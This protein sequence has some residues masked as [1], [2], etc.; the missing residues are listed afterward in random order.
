MLLRM[1][2]RMAAALCA[3]EREPSIH[4]EKANPSEKARCAHCE[5]VPAMAMRGHHNAFSL[6][7]TRYMK[8]MTPGTPVV[9]RVDAR[10]RA[11]LQP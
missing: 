9:R 1:G 8:Y 7:F 6:R 2:A 10:V 4:S 5:M 3:S 11:W